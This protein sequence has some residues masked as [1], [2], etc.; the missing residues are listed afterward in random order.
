MR[1]SFITTCIVSMYLLCGGLVYG[2]AEDFTVTESVYFCLVT[3]STVGYGDLSP[4]SAGTR[5]FTVV[6]IL[7]GARG[8]HDAGRRAATRIQYQIA[9]TS[10]IQYYTS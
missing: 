9:E 8:E 7:V 5:F 3:M 2:F 4:T 1:D 6:M 10:R